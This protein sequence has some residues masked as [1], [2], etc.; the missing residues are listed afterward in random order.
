VP[1]RGEIELDV[2]PLF[3]ECVDGSRGS[4]LLL[5]GSFLLGLFLLGHDRQPMGNDRVPQRRDPARTSEIG[6]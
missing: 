1:L 5:L 2:D 4:L 6:P 3:G